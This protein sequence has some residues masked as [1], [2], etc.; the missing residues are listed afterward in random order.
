M[1]DPTEGALLFLGQKVG[2][3]PELVRQE[4]KIIDEIPFDSVTKRMTVVVKNSESRI[5]N[6]ELIFSKGAPESILSICDK[7]LINGKEE[8][9]GLEEKEQVDKQ[10]EEWGRKGLR[11]LGF[12]YKQTQSLKLKTQNHNSKLKFE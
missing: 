11:V 1:G 7:Q 2:L 3:N 12:A 5:Q 9:F 6:S 10:V 8:K 4:W